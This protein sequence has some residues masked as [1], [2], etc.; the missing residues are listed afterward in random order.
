MSTES[1][2]DDDDQ[3]GGRSFGDLDDQVI[4]RA[5]EGV[6]LLLKQRATIESTLP[7]IQSRWLAD[8]DVQPTLNNLIGTL[9][10]E[11]GEVTLLLRV[12]DDFGLEEV[13]ETCHGHGELDDGAYEA[14]TDLLGRMEWIAPAAEAYYQSN[15]SNGHYWTDLRMG[16]AGTGDDGQLLFGQY[17]ADG[18]DEL[19]D[20]QAPMTEFVRHSIRELA[21]VINAL[22]QLPPSVELNDDEL[23]QLQGLAESLDRVSDDFA[24]TVDRTAEQGDVPDTDDIEFDELV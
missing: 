13:L 9:D 5:A 7:N 17:A 12:V 23:E 8:E 11:D 16:L 2:D 18:V 22:Q 15:Q 10:G 6:K 4:E 19:W 20:V 3:G 21:M 24:E 1:A 14:A